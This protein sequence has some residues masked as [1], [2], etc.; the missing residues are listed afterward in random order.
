MKYLALYLMAPMQSWGASSKF[1]ERETL[2][3]PTRSGLLGMLAAACGVDKNDAACDR[4]WLSRAAELA[5]SIYA[6]RRGD[7]M[8]DFHTVGSRYDTDA[9]WQRRMIPTTADGKPRGTDVTHRDY[10]SDSVFGAVL[11]GDDIFVSEIAVG[12]ADPVWGVWLGRKSCIPTEP[13][14]VGVYDSEAAA[15]DALIARFRASRMRSN[16]RNVGKES[17]NPVFSVI[18]AG[19]ENAEEVVF[20]VPTSF[21]QRKYC[22][23][24]I[25]HLEL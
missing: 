14:F 20:D 11:S 5:L 1:G 18:E 13:I 16:A 24:R 9:P 22:A 23:R 17:G 2:D 21:G 25:R 7:R 8:T 15:K 4:R 19:A 3:A 12:I 10:L 6:F